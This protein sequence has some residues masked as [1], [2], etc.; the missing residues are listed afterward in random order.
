MDMNPNIPKA[1]WGFNG[2]ERPGAVYLAATSVCMGIAG[3]IVNAD[4]LQEYLGMRTEYVDS[5]EIIRR[6]E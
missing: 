6:I 4:F 5:S 3:S 2:T 1:I